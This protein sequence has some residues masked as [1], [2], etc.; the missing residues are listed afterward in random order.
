MRWVRS[1]D[2]GA[3]AVITA[4][5]SIVLF[6]VAALTVDIGRLWETR[7][8][9]QSDVDLATLAGALHLRDADETAAC[10]TAL[11]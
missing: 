1:D 8:Q 3:V 7:R 4:I 10:K 9:A 11:K 5:V 2:A 6:G